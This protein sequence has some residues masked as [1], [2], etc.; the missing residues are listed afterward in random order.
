MKKIKSFDSYIKEDLLPGGRGDNFDAS[1]ADPQELE[2]GIEVE[3]E[4]V[5]DNR[6]DLA[7]EIALDHLAENPKYY[8]IAVRVGLIDEEPA[9]RLARKF[10]WE[11]YKLH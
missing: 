8:S 6:E 2:V 11:L 3:K 5:E 1:D 7:Q 10:G 9:L 4:H